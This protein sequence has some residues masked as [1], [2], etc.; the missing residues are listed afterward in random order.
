MVL[1]YAYFLNAYFQYPNRFLESV[2][3]INKF[4]PRPVA[5]LW[6]TKKKCEHEREAVA[7]KCE[8]EREAKFSHSNFAVLEN[9]RVLGSTSILSKKK[10]VFMQF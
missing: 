10:E 5:L 6:L 3:K 9:S 7:E 8:H 2:L 4:F 1:L